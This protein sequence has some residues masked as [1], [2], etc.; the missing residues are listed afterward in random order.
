MRWIHDVST[1]PDD[2]P[3]FVALRDTRL[4]CPNGADYSG[5][6][7]GAHRLRYLDIVPVISAH[8][9]QQIFS[10]ALACAKKLEWEIAASVEA[11]GRIEAT[12]TT[13]IMRFKDDVVIR[14]CPA[15]NGSRLDMRSASR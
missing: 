1:A 15:G 11:E 13:R 14:I 6:D 7:A 2:P 4:A 8:A 12:A 5:L 3:R 9:Q 10:T